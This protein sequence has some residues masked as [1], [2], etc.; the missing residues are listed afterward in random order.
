MIDKTPIPGLDLNVSEAKT[1]INNFWNYLDDLA[2]NNP[3]EYKKFIS[4]QMKKGM[5]MAQEIKKEKQEKE[6][7]Q[8][9]KKE[10]TFLNENN[11]NSIYSQ[12]ILTKK[13][14]DVFPFKCLRF[15]PIKIFKNNFEEN[16][17]NNP[18]ILP[19][20]IKNQI[21][22]LKFTFGP[23]FT[24]NAFKSSIIQ[25]RKIYLNI[26]YSEDFYP[27]TDEKG[28]F[29][30]E[31]QLDDTNNWKYIPTEFRYVGKQN[32]RSDTRCDFYDMII[33]KLVVDK[34]KKD[35]NLYKTMLGY[36]GKKF[37]IFTNDK[38]LL[39]TES[40]K[41][42]EKMYKSLTSKPEKFKS[43]M[44]NK[45]GLDKKDEKN[46][47]KEL[48]NNNNN[49][50]INSNNNNNNLNSNK[51]PE[52]IIHESQITK[53]DENEITEDN[54]KLSQNS[55]QKKINIEE[56]GS[57]NKLIIPIKKKILDDCHMECKFDFEEFEYLKGISEIDLLISKEGIIIHLDNPHYIIDKN[58][59]PVEMKFNFKVNP[60]NCTAK[61]SKK[62][63]QLTVVIERIKE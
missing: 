51:T 24:D 29:L 28:N 23:Q 55:E 46:N 9:E 20:E 11:L 33:N 35:N 54:I 47:N 16:L 43:K 8:N 41:I 57:E 22:K 40:V 42:I 38:F 39:F 1:Q 7:E 49:K 34:M 56:V 37:V 14:F 12:N 30:N 4:T 19:E 31:K 32:S 59:E 53:K 60:D 27:P 25:N 5:E 17:D 3:E 63:K 48:I 62:L 2:K 36:I 61:Y 45:I 6:K 44:D 26:L 58:Y 50:N 15:K 13:E 21:E 18:N 10:E 52:I